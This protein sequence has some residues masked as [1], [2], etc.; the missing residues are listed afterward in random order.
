LN[1]G[2]KSAVPVKP[3]QNVQT[4]H[5]Q[6]DDP[7]NTPVYQMEPVMTGKRQHYGATKDT[8]RNIYGK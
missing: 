3:L 7:G 1:F 4:G 6:D 5:H 2:K 8:I